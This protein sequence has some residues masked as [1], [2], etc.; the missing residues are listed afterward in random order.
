MNQFFNQRLLRG[1]AEADQPLAKMILLSLQEDLNLINFTESADFRFKDEYIGRVNK[2]TAIL[3][4]QGSV[5]PDY[6]R[7]EAR[8][9]LNFPLYVDGEIGDFDI[10]L[11]REKWSKARIGQAGK[12]GDAHHVNTLVLKLMQERSVTY[13]Q[14]LSAADSYLQEC[15]NSGRL[16][17]DL[18]NFI[19]DGESWFIMAYID[20]SV[21]KGD[22]TDV[23]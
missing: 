7:T 22:T 6:K 18:P 1:V 10:A 14:V 8:L 21:S 16:I 5:V 13:D 3:I 12:M 2:I 4:N 17:R 15:M 20:E 9:V 11:L 23:L 19:H